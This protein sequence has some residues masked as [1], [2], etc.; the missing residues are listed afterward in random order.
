M[1]PHGSKGAENHVR[2]VGYTAAVAGVGDHRR[3]Q[4]ASLRQWRQFSNDA[5]MQ[6]YDSMIY[7]QR[8]ARKWSRLPS[9]SSNL[10]I[11]DA[12]EEEDGLLESGRP[13]SAGLASRQAEY[14]RPHHRA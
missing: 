10:I 7:M 12:R 6:I 13:G 4:R 11:L 8:D 1:A 3:R 5:Q 9:F 14:Y 2:R